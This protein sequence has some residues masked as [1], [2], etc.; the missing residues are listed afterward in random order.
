MAVYEVPPLLHSHPLDEFDCPQANSTI[1]V[2]RVALNTTRTSTQQRQILGETRQ[3]ARQPLGDCE[4][5]T[6]LGASS[7]TKS[8]T[9]LVLD[10]R[11]SSAQHRRP[12]RPRRL[13]APQRSRRGRTRCCRARRRPETGRACPRRTSKRPSYSSNRILGTREALESSMSLQQVDW[14]RWTL[15][16]HCR[17]ISGT[18]PSRPALRARLLSRC[19]RLGPAGSP[20]HL[21]LRD[22]STR[23]PEKP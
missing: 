4:V 2:G 1:L 8:T 20:N 17:A 9:P 10:L 22:A 18:H 12:E 14:L 15:R 11:R 16:F 21:P 23:N 5:C 7:G 13:V 3:V 19:N 6:E